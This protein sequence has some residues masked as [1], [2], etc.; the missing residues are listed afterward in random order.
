M[1]E[2]T[3]VNNGNNGKKEKGRVRFNST[4][5]GE[6]PRLPSLPASPTATGFGEEDKLASPVR[7]PRP[8]IIRGVSYNSVLDTPGENDEKAISAA[9]AHQRAQAVAATMLGSFSAP[10]SRRGSLESDISQFSSSGRFINSPGLPLEDIHDTGTGI[11]TH[12]DIER[13]TSQERRN[14][15]AAAYELVRAHTQH[16][17]HNPLTDDHLGANLT[18]MPG[19][20]TLPDDFTRLDPGNLSQLDLSQ[21]G[22]PREG[23]LTHLL[24][25]YKVTEM[26]RKEF[27]GYTTPG[28]SGTAT[29]NSRR[30]WY[31][32]D[33]NSSQS[34]LQ[35]LAAASTA[36]ANPNEKRGRTP[37]GGRPKHKRSPSSKF[38]SMIGGKPRMEEEAR[39]TIHVANIL[40]RQQY[41]IKLCRALMLF[42]APTHRLEEYLR[43]IARVLEIDGQFLYL[44]G[45]MIISFDDMSTHTTEV[46]IVR[47]S[48]GV[49]L[50]KLKDV[51]EIYKEVLHDCITLDE[52]T[53]RLDDILKSKDRFNPWLRVVMYGFASATVAPFAFGGRPI[54]MPICF[55]LGCLIGFLQLIVAPRSDVYNNVFEICAAV[56]TSFLARAFGSIRNGE[57]FCFSA[58]AQSSIALILPGYLVL[59]SALELQSRA[60]VPGSIRMVYAIIYSLFLGF[61]ITV[62]TAI[63]G[64]I[65]SNAVST[66]SCSNTLD[67]H[68]N[69]LFVPAFAFCL[70]Y[71]NQAKW[72]QMPVMILIAM[73]GYVV[74]YF[75]SL[76][77]PSSAQMS[78]TL[79]ALT[80]GVAANLY[81]RLRH[82]VAAAALLPAIF[83]QVP[84]GLAATG[85]LLSGLATANELTNSTQTVNGTTTVQIT[86]SSNNS[87]DTVVFNVAASMIQIAVGITV[88]LFFATLLIYP[89][90]KRRSGLFTF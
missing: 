18:R 89:F 80:V 11:E 90:G 13:T 69:F 48:Q 29:P 27:S 70:T 22:T 39:I 51:H 38:M 8:S 53:V 81:S 17:H 54:D 88:G 66:T 73:S 5:A 3:G 10:G 19:N 78:N 23:V 77:F 32:Q 20:S 71:V 52:A 7:R 75:T 30:K 43:M 46:K 55:I 41:I 58:I 35:T 79:G 60:I 21:Q 4:A 16:L 62:G 26:P 36:L 83:V 68:W 2:K 42:G 37:G 12:A 47:V 28:S 84:S 49:N 74:N 15:N 65:D 85:S 14:H 25:L 64:W 57:V 34:T 61:G 63:Y 56:L 59:C 6:P 50:G 1:D 40:K 87:M 9:A 31:A 72:T 86:S 76:R 24:K 45:C 67:S 44:P 33:K 82:G